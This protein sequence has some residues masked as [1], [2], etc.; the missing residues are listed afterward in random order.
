MEINKIAQDSIVDNRSF[1]SLFGI[2]F[3]IHDF[4]CSD[5][6]IT[7]LKVSDKYIIS[8]IND[9][10]EALGVADQYNILRNTYIKGLS[11]LTI[12]KDINSKKIKFKNK[13]DYKIYN[14]QYNFMDY[15]TEEQ[16][17]IYTDVFLNSIYKS[18]NPIRTTESKITFKFESG[19]TKTLTFINKISKNNSNIEVINEYRV[20]DGFFS[21]LIKKITNKSNQKSVLLVKTP[22]ANYD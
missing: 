2:E 13:E 7:G 5:I 12:K 9:L 10:V 20:L 17:K 22:L 19:I 4:L 3:K 6:K 1:S 16:L 14:E 21:R 11:I 8:N 15:T 18:E